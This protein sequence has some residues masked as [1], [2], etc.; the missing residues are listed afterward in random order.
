MTR[1]KVKQLP[2]PNRVF[3]WFQGRAVQVGA[4]TLCRDAHQHAARVRGW[5]A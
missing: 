3:V 1:K 5:V 4:Y 2:T